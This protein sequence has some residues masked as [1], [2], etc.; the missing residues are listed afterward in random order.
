MMKIIEQISALSVEIDEAM[1]TLGGVSRVICTVSDN[2]GPF[3]GFGWGPKV[4]L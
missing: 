1:P 4:L 3:L 2:P